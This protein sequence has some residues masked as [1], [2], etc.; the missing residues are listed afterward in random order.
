MVETV[1]QDF[2][3]IVTNRKVPTPWGKGQA[4]NIRQGS[5]LSGPVGEDLEGGDMNET[6]LVLAGFGGDGQDLGVVVEAHG[7][8]GGS[9]VSDGAQGLGCAGL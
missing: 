8:D 7:V 6:Q 1:E 5:T 9:Q 3:L 4:G 2:T